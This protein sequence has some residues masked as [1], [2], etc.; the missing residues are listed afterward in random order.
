MDPVVDVWS[1]LVRNLPHVTPVGTAN[2]NDV[3]DAEAISAGIE[4]WLQAVAVN[5]QVAVT[6]GD[7]GFPVR[8]SDGRD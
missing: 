4:N 8:T 3:V 5:D 1:S 2:G 7:V 6:D